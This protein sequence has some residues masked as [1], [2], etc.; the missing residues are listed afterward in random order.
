VKTLIENSSEQIGGKFWINVC[1]PKYYEM[2]LLSKASYGFI[3]I[4]PQ[5]CMLNVW[6]LDCDVILRGG[7]KFRNSSYLEEVGHWVHE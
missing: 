4:F 2:L 3:I 7:G 5:A 1:K 6:L